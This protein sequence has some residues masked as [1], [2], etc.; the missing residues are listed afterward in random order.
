MMDR[1][2]RSGSRGCI[3]HQ[4][5]AFARDLRMQHLHLQHSS[6]VAITPNTSSYCSKLVGTTSAS[7]TAS[8]RSTRLRAKRPPSGS[9]CLRSALLQAAAG[10]LRSCGWHSCSCL[11]L[12]APPASSSSSPAPC[13][14]GGSGWRRGSICL[15]T[16]C[17]HLLLSSA[18]S[19]SEGGGLLPGCFRRGR[20]LDSL[21]APGSASGALPA[22]GAVMAG[23]GRRCRAAGGGGGAAAAG[24]AV[25]SWAGATDAAGSAAAAGAGAGAGSGRA[26][27]P[28]GAAAVT[29]PTPAPA[30]L[31]PARAACAPVT[32]AGTPAAG[33]LLPC[34]AGSADVV[35]V[36][37]VGA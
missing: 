9:G 19:S 17:M 29:C 1:V 15:S 2:L 23:T 4:R 28:A 34:C 13:G 37:V 5:P 24:D 21:R 3:F 25:G 20:L 27:V 26:E 22:P 36:V 14:G 12:G 7:V 33:L 32:V 35:V 8:G 6:S 18:G 31:R 30:S 16:R 11:T 10:A